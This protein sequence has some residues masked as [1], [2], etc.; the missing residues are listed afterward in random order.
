[1]GRIWARWLPALAVVPLLGCQ[2]GSD[3]EVDPATSAPSALA[4]TIGG[5]HASPP[6]VVMRWLTA[7]AGTIAV[8]E[9]ELL[10]ENPHP[11]RVDFELAIVSLGLDQRTLSKAMG[12]HSLEPGDKKVLRIDI[13]SLP[14]RSATSSCELIAQAS[15]S[16]D[17]HGP[18]TVASPSLY[19]HVQAGPKPVAV[20]YDLDGL[21][22]TFHGGSVDEQTATA[23]GEV[24]AM[25]GSTKPVTTG[26]EGSHEAK[27]G[28]RFG[29]GETTL[30]FQPTMDLPASSDEVTYDAPTN[31]RF[32]WRYFQ[33]CTHWKA[34]FTDAGFGEDYAA[35]Q[36]L[37]DLKARHAFASVRRT[38]DGTFLWTGYLDQNGCTPSVELPPGTYELLQNSVVNQGSKTFLVYHTVS[39]SSQLA[40]VTSSFTLLSAFYQYYSATQTFYPTYHQPVTRVTGVMGQLMAT[41][42]NG[43]VD[44]TYVVKANTACPGATY[45][46]YRPLD[47]IAYIETADSNWKVIVAHEVGHQIESRAIGDLS[48]NYAQ[49]ATQTLC[50]CDQVVDSTLRAHCL[51]SREHLTTAQLEGFAQFA[52]AKAF[53]DPAQN[54]CSFAYYKEFRQPQGGG[55]WYDISPPMARGCR[56]NQTWMESYCSTSNRG[57]EWDWQI[58]YWNL[59]TV[60]TSKTTMPQFWA[61]YRSACGGSTC[62]NTEVS[63]TALDA[64]ARTYHGLGSAK[65]QHF[66]TTSDNAGVNH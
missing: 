42:D 8:D 32:G 35:T 46:C 7:A 24:V 36:G 30:S 2:T 17:A 56:D 41:P 66:Q 58:F 65:Y 16:R 9:M 59:N 29:L 39:G 50:R 19:Y 13:A 20:A 11:Q 27:A 5:E 45:S 1:M 34:Q 12:A 25:D 6:P 14:L 55:Q 37:Q 10:L 3:K 54:D 22:D 47:Q 61:I 60:S 62:Q 4:E 63:W 21:V 64:A 26:A 44:G 53:N 33:M 15:V 28:A 43:I 18:V 31:L 57:V 49:D 40:T 38:S 23:T 48:I 51:Q 52:A